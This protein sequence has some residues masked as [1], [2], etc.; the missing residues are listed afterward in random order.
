MGSKEEGVLRWSYVISEGLEGNGITLRDGDPESPKPGRNS[1]VF[2]L[3]ADD[4]E[5][6]GRVHVQRMIND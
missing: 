2:S 3:C 5:S 4:W 1:L 6:G